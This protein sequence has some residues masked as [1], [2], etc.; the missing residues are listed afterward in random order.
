LLNI[1][2]PSDRYEICVLG[3][4][5]TPKAVCDGVLPDNWRVIE[6]GEKEPRDFLAE[7]D[8]FVYFTHPDWVEAFGRVIFE[9]MAVGLPVVLPPTYERLFQDA[10]IYAEPQEVAQKVDLLM[11]DDAFYENQVERA[12]A[13]V[14]SKFGYSQHEARI[15]AA[16]SSE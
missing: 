15:R 1:Y 13:Y 2:P 12:R 14:E 7:H 16:M 6:F 3:G 11:G 4:A 5:E 9:A 10:A 8:V